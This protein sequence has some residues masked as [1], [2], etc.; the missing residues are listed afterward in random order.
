MFPVSFY[1]ENHRC[2]PPVSAV[3][4]GANLFLSAS[5]SV[6]VPFAKL[7]APLKLG[8]EDVGVSS[9]QFEDFSVMTT[10]TDVAGKLKVLALA[11]T[12][13]SQIDL[14]RT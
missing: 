4:S 13:T 5:S 3:L 7:N 6:F 2:F 10:S 1:R 14:A 9:S 12:F 8:A 11:D